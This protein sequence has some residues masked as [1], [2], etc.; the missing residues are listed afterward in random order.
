MSRKPAIAVVARHELITADGGPLRSTCRTDAT[1]NHRRNNDAAPD[2][3]RGIVTRGNNPSADFVAE[4][5]WQRF[6]RGNAI[7]RKADIG[8][9]Y[10]AARD[11]YH[12]FLRPGFERRKFESL[13]GLADRYQPVSMPAINSHVPSLPILLQSACWPGV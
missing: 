10:A 4:H 5:E 7:D 11:L 2:P 13:Q 9:T 8:V 3:T 6:S 12:S 1:R